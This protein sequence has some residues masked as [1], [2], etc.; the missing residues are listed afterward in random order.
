MVIKTVTCD[1]ECGEELNLEE[2]EAIQFKSGIIL[3][4]SCYDNQFEDLV[5]D[6]DES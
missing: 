2:D 6:I 1:G 4:Q 3:C 5:R